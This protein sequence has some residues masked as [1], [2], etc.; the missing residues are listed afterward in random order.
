M[1][2]LSFLVGLSMVAAQVPQDT[3][4]VDLPD[5][6][7]IILEEPVRERLLSAFRAWMES[8]EL[9]GACLYGGVVETYQGRALN[10][11]GILEVNEPNCP[12][13]LDYDN[14]LIG[15]LQF[16]NPISFSISKEQLMSMSCKQLDIVPLYYRVVGYM[17]GIKLFPGENGP[18][19][20]E[21]AVGCV[22]TR[23]Q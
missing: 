11:T 16:I 1:G 6:P 13:Y 7:Q 4:V 8:P 21:E 17:V 5:I 14:Q 19:S 20:Y 12:F 23:Q 15:F 18:R 22:R 10:A 2:L 9:S 3:V